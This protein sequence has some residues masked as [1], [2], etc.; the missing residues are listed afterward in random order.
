MTKGIVL[1]FAKLQS[2]VFELTPHH[3]SLPHVQKLAEY[4][5]SDPA[6]TQ[7]LANIIARR[8]ARIDTQYQYVLQ[9]APQEL[10]ALRDAANKVIDE[11][12]S[13]QKPAL[14]TTILQKLDILNSLLDGV[15]E[16]NPS[17]RLKKMLPEWKHFRATL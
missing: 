2:P 14:K 13:K 6:F 10:H 7:Q 3:A 15:T 1:T 16:T 4:V 11:L 12:N 8:A 5:Q 9:V 17:E